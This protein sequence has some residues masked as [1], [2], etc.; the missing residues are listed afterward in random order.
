MPRADLRASAALLVLE[1]AA[2]RR[3]ELLL[4]DELKRRY[5][6]RD[7]PADS[8]QALQALRAWLGDTGFV[9]RPSELLADGYGLPQSEERVRVA[10][11]A[12]LR[13]ARLREQDG[14][15][16]EELER[17]LP[18]DQREVLRGIEANLKTIGVRLRQP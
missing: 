2:Q 5:L 6:G 11:E 3:Q 10:E 7:A 18:A 8:A 1:N 9:S 14:V 17:W 4:R 12:R 13:V 16:R 15:L